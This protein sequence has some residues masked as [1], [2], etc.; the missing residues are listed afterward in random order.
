MVNRSPIKLI[1][2]NNLEKSIFTWEI[3]IL[4]HAIPVKMPNEGPSGQSW[5]WFFYML[6]EITVGIYLQKNRGDLG[7]SQKLWPNVRYADTL[8]K[9]LGS[10]VKIDVWSGVTGTL[11]LILAFWL[12]GSDLDSR[13]FGLWLDLGWFEPSDWPLIAW[14]RSRS[15]FWLVH[16]FGKNFDLVLPAE[17]FR[18]IS[19]LGLSPGTI[20]A[21]I[22]IKIR[23]QK[24]KVKIL[25]E[26]IFCKKLWR[27]P[28]SIPR[29]GSPRVS[30]WHL[31]QNVRGIWG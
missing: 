17:P 18:A 8:V 20:R 25:E 2:K 27:R 10:G 31:H 29:Q 28:G 23:I 6:W 24:W 9:G 22:E 11:L 3:S 19:C 5:I 13:A 15:W 12:V 21:K 30:F 4:K 14:L 1:L 16:P 26:K 7:G